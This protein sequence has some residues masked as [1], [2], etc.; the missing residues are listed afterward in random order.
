MQSSRPGRSRIYAIGAA[1]VAVLTIS[2]SMFSIAVFT[3][4]D[5]V[6][7][8]FTTG[9]ISLVAGSNPASVA[10]TDMMPGDDSRFEITVT[11]DGSGDLRYA[12][13]AT[14]DGDLA[15]APLKL[16]V[17]TGECADWSTGTG[18]VAEA[19]LVG[20]GFGDEAQ[21]QDSG[22]RPLAATASETFCFQVGLPL[23]TGNDYQD[24]S[25]T[26]TFTFYAE[27]TANNP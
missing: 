21:G 15:D 5:S 2:V 11:N 22:D 10:V 1:A 4:D 26:A 18:V 12:M 23:A 9:D 24:A 6:D 8:D 3:D 19:D 27:Q 17:R 7:A 13:E 20:A 14:A 16:T 25:A